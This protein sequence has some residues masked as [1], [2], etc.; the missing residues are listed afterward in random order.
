MQQ[1]LFGLILS[2]ND[3]RHDIVLYFCSLSSR[4]IYLYSE[5]AGVD[6]RLKLFTYLYQM[7]AV[8]PIITAFLNRY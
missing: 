5:F 2:W 3:E 4:C 6:V 1:R 7:Y 8:E